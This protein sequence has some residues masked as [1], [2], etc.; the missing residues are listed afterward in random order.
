[1]HI[2]IDMGQGIVYE[3][4]VSAMTVSGGSDGV[5]ADV[6]TVLTVDTIR[7]DA[8]RVPS[9]ASLLAFTDAIMTLYRGVAVVWE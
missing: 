6:E 2:R 3:G 4:V 1:M 7:I 8:S 5:M 9:A